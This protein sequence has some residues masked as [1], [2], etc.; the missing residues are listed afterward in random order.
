MGYLTQFA[1]KASRGR[2]AWAFLLLTALSLI[3]TIDRTLNAIWRVRRAAAGAAGADVLGGADAGAA[4]AGGQPGADVLRGV[5]LARAGGQ[6][7][8][9]RHGL[10]WM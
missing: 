6:P 1:A 3:L 7:C 2:G 5:G 8:P 4:A 10:G 9:W